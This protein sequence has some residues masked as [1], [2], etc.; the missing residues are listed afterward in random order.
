MIDLL[1]FKYYVSQYFRSIS[2]RPIALMAELTPDV[3]GVLSDQYGGLRKMADAVNTYLSVWFRDEWGPS[4]NI[5]AADFIRS[6]TI[7]ETAMYWNSQKGQP[8]TVRYHVIEE[9]GKK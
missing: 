8:A 7:V 4:V 5:V 1:I 9:I 2:S 3:W 6:T